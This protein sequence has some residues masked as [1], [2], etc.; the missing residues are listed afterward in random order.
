MT[1]ISTIHFSL[2][3]RCNLK[4]PFC[5]RTE[6]K[7]ETYEDFCV[8]LIDRLP[9]SKVENLVFAGT[10]GDFSFYPKLFELLNRCK[11]LNSDALFTMFTNGTRNTT[12]WWSEFGKIMNR[13]NHKVFFAVDGLSDTH[14]KHRIGANFNK[15]IENIKEFISAGGSAYIQF[16][17]F[18]HNEHQMD[19][20]RQLA[21]NI[22]CKDFQVKISFNYDDEFKK[23]I[24]H[25]ILT[26]HEETKLYRGEIECRLTDFTELFVGNNNDI[27]PC[28][29]LFPGTYHHFFQDKPLNLKDYDGDMSLESY[30]EDFEYVIGCRDA[31][32]ICNIRCRSKLKQ[33]LYTPAE[34]R[35]K[36]IR[37]KIKLKRQGI[38]L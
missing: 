8:D 2:T 26:R 31:N 9:I 10:L 4:C 21:K 29:Q 34:I 37:D 38:I 30:F 13:S 1:D 7:Q 20:L 36:A 14:S 28:C 23:P 18:E 19:E 22:G 32:P 6:F 12:G 5:S 33:I 16:I 11:S 15:I 27:L 17:I 25:N 35:L 3:N 24:K